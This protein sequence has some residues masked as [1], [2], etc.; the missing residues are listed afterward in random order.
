V[1]EHGID[2]VIDEA[3]VN[4]SS[5]EWFVHVVKMSQV[6]TIFWDLLQTQ[7]TVLSVNNNLVQ[8]EYIQYDAVVME[9]HFHTHHANRL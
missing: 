4:T 8:N 3:Q 9:Q 6:S 5:N 1:R 7:N 2:W